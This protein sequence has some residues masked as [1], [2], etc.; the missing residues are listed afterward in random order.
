MKNKIIIIVSVIIVISIAG[1][2]SFP[3]NETDEKKPASEVQDD[4]QISSLYSKIEQGRIANEKSGEFDMYKSR[5]WITSGPFQIDRSV[6]HLGEKIFINVE[7][8]PEN[9]EGK[10]VFAKIF[11]N[12]HSKIYKT[13]M[14]DGGTPQ[15]N[16]YFAVFPSLPR[17]FCTI[18]D[19]VGDWEVTFEGTNLAPLE[20]KILNKFVPGNEDYFDPVC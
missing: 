14:F 16:S 1:V 19:I 20:F 17:Q 9:F 2:F 8:L 12:T 4:N 11:N 7:T 3:Q 13:L 5:E 15:Q 10:M 18:D 6:Y